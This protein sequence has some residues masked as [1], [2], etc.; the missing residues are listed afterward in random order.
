MASKTTTYVVRINNQDGFD[1]RATNTRPYTHAVVGPW[2]GEEAAYTWHTSEALA[3]KSLQARGPEAKGMRV[4]EAFGRNGSKV[5]VTKQLRAELA[6]AEAPAEEAPKAKAKKAEPK[7]ATEKKAPKAKAE[8]TAPVR[9]KGKV[10]KADD[11]TKMAGYRTHTKSRS[12]KTTAVLVDGGEQGL[13]TSA[14][15]W[16]TICLDHSFIV[17]HSGQ[18]IARDVLGHPETWCQ[19]CAEAFAAQA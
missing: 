4:V 12:S 3:H 16:Q 17:A 10:K 11:V 18:R 13:D 6:A 14:G 1:T 15:K 8:P 9:V 2:E 5:T 7:K 19:P